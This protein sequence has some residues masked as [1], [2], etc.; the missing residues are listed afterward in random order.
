MEVK[1]YIPKVS[2]PLLPIIKVPEVESTFY[3]LRLTP[4]G[5]YTEKDAV[6]FLRTLGESYILSKEVSSKDKE[7]YHIVLSTMFYEEELREKIRVFLRTVFTEP[8]RRGDAN[9]QYNLQECLDS[10]MA[11][12]YLL[13][14]GGEIFLG[15]NINDDA[16]NM[17]RKLSYKKFSKA[18]FAKELEDIKKLFKEKKY[19]LQQMMVEVVKLKAKYRQPININYIH[20]LCLGF[21]IH[22]NPGYA[23][24]IVQNYFL[25]IK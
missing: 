6:N 17:R 14:D 16:V 12:A 24:E 5:K 20:Q 21:Y 4:M 9:K 23:D 15:M 10:D 18:E 22:V 13:K 19:T 1:D 7:H 11:V 2:E 25:G 3:V 8:P